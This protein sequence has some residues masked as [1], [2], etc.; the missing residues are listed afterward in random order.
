VQWV[1]LSI[2]QTVY[3]NAK[4]AYE[5]KKDYFWKMTTAVSALMS[6]IVMVF[7]IA[8]IAACSDGALEFVIPVFIIV[9]IV[10]IVVLVPLFD[11][12]PKSL[13]DYTDTHLNKLL[14]TK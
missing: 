8:G 3:E 4:K 14:V 7:V 13:Y 1:K 9:G 11:A 5:G 12:W 10:L 6:L 2:D